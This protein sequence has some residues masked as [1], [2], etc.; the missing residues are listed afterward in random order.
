MAGAPAISISGLS[1]ELGGRR[2]LDNLSLEVARGEMIG[3]VGASGSG[4][5]VLLRTML[6]LLPKSAGQVE[7]LGLP[8]ENASPNEVRA[9]GR[10]C[11]AMFQQ[12]ALFSS[13][14]VR[15]NVEFPMREYLDG[16]DRLFRS[17]ALAKLRMVGLSE[18]DAEK[19]P[20][21]LSGGM[22]KRAAL[23]RAL[24]LDPDIVFLD[25]P[26]SGLDPIAA[27]D[28]DALI[29]SLHEMLGLTL[30]MITHDL[31]TLNAVCDRVAALH[32]GHIIADGPMPILLQSDHPWLKA[33]FRGE[34]GRAIQWAR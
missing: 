14:S 11:G 22:T 5:T 7:I 31:E 30:F 1:V 9:I 21:Q 25:E 23:A 27:G 4:K 32:E 33:Y 34:R 24:A 28:F 8:L 18:T 13:L 6:G 19:M 2:I 16:S 20:A 10:R 26:T 12:G 17:V 15:E 3:L 29:R